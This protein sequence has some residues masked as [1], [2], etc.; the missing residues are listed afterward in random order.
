MGNK[1]MPTECKYCKKIIE[2]VLKIDEGIDCHVCPECGHIIDA[3]TDNI[4]VIGRDM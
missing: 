1:E 3:C 2:P 4:Q